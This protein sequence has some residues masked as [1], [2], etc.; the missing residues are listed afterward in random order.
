MDRESDQPPDRPIAAEV[1]RWWRAEGREFPWRLTGDA[2]R[3]LIAEMLLQRSR[4]RSVAQVYVGI[5]ERWPT[6]KSIAEADVSEL[7]DLI[8]PLGFQSRAEKIKDIA[9]EWS[10]RDFPPA[11][12]GQLQL[13]PGI[14]PYSANA[15]AIAMSWDADPCVDSVSIRVLRRFIGDED[16]EHSDLEV[17]SEVY[18]Q[19]PR[20]HWSALNWAVLDLA[21]AICMPKNPRCNDC[22]VES[23]C[24]WSQRYRH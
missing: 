23:Q 13:L 3:I 9:K 16:V 24:K 21:A 1:I 2:F 20:L 7:R 17:A 5:F 10:A 4:S 15:T 18:F 14:G 19:V 11:S 6:A 12:A 8:R 22:P